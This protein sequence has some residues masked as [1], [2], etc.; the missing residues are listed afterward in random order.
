[1]LEVIK[2]MAKGSEDRKTLGLQAKLG[3][4]GVDK[5]KI[6]GWIEDIEEDE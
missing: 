5:E 6:K 1:M 2:I 4:Q 3:Q